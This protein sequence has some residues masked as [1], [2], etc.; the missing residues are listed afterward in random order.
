MYQE[1]VL[2]TYRNVNQSQLHLAWHIRVKPK[3]FTGEK[4][5]IF[6]KNSAFSPLVKPL[7]WNGSPLSKPPSPLRL[8]A[9]LVKPLRKYYLRLKMI[10]SFLEFDIFWESLFTFMLMQIALW[11][12]LD[13]S[14]K[15]EFTK[16][17]QKEWKVNKLCCL[18]PENTCTNN[19][20]S[21]EIDTW[22]N[23]FLGFWP[24]TSKFTRKEGRY[25]HKQ[26]TLEK[27]SS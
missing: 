24:K 23:F 6:S 22:F 8:A 26:Y 18:F 16:I 12:K 3:W 17:M 19:I 20:S 13:S 27:L 5:L 21:T 1:I 2:R 10:I 15:K 25:R 14:S 9:S 11:H 4:P 7:I